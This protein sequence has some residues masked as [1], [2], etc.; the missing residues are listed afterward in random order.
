MKLKREWAT[1]AVATAAIAASTIHDR[2]AA[3]EPR[4][5]GTLVELVISEPAHL[6]SP[7]GGSSTVHEASSK[8][9]DT[10]LFERDGNYEPRLAERWT[11]APDGKSFT[12]HL[13]RTVRWHDGKPFT[14]ADVAFSL[15]EIWKKFGGNVAFSRI[16]RVETP[17]PHTVIFHADEPVAPQ[18]LLSTVGSYQGAVLPKHVYEG[19]DYRS[20]RANRAPIGTGPFRFKEWLPGQYL[21]FERNADYYRQP[22]PYLDRVIVRVERNAAT[23]SAALESGAAHLAVR[24]PVSLRDLPRIA[25]IPSLAYSSVGSEHAGWHQLMEFNTQRE[26]TKNRAVRQAIAYAIDKKKLLDVVFVGRGKVATGP[27]PSSIPTYTADVATYPFDP[28]KAET[29][30]DREGYTRNADGSRFTLNFVIGAYF[31]TGL[32]SVE[33]IRQNLAD[34]GI[35]TNI[36]TPDIAAFTRRVYKDY[37]FDI[38]ISNSVAFSEPGTG[39]FAWLWSKGI[40]P[41]VPFRNASRYSNP[42]MD[43]VIEAALREQDRNKRLALIH[44]FQKI[45]ARDLPILYLIEMDQINVYNKRVRNVGN[46]PRWYYTSWE[47]VWLEQ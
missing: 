6:V 4:R 35:K 25:Q 34:I 24:S 32:Q 30:L 3:Q 42:E 13:N 7:F 47:D 40:V 29:L 16:A 45:A 20:N 15:Q 38:T 36:H 41:G 8:V 31:E 44:Q 33:I 1:L 2:A 18:L 21:V 37:D 27:I 22:F 10:L 17:D 5:G 26:I 14:A 19:T 39:T 11:V 23:R 43:E 12:F 9:F 28:K 46:N